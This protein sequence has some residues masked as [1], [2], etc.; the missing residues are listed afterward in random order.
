MGSRVP[1]AVV[2]IEVEVPHAVPPLPR[3]IEVLYQRKP[4]MDGSTHKLG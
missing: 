2:N 3:V 4:R 1:Q